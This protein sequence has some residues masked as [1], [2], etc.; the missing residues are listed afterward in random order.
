MLRAG[1]APRHVRRAVLEIEVHFH[2]LVDDGL[3]RGESENDANLKAQGLLGTDQTLIQRYADMPELRSW[4][5]RW[6]AIWFTIVPLLS[7]MALFVATMAMFSLIG[8]HMA[9]HQM[10]V[11]ARAS[12]R[13]DLAARITC[14]WTIPLLL[15]GAFAVLAYRRR[16]APGWP[17]AGIL[18]MCGL[19]SL[20][21]VGVALPDGVTRGQTAAGIGI[22]AESLPGQILHAAVIAMLVLA[23]LWLAL[24]RLRREGAIV[25]E[26]GD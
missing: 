13:I 14:L 19:A 15:A 1:V 24:R 7:F 21:N 26:A 12:Y 16:I 22:S 8:H 6:T 10:H 5:S 4:A 17:V 20:I 11:S 3:A 23:P 9:V 25:A 18:I 2:Q